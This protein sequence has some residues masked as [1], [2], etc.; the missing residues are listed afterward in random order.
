MLLHLFHLIQLNKVML[1]HLFHLIQLNKVMLRI[2]A[3]YFST[4]T[5][6]QTEGA[7]K[8]PYSGWAHFWHPSVEP[9]KQHLLTHLA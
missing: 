3:P 6:R 9:L 1:L 2:F 8:S 7:A 4:G 5:G